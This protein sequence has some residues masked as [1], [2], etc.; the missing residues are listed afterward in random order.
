MLAELVPGREYDPREIRGALG[1]GG[2]EGAVVV[3]RGRVALFCRVDATSGGP[4]FPERSS[5]EWP[6]EVPKRAVDAKTRLLVFVRISDEAVRYLGE[7]RATRYSSR[8]GVACDVRFHITPPLERLWWLELIA[9]RLPP[10]GAPP[11][12]ALAN[13]TVESSTSERWA[14]LASFLERWFGKAFAELPATTETTIGPPLLRR[15]LRVHA[16][17][18]DVVMHNQLVRPEELI[19]EDGKIVFL[20]ENQGVCLWATEPDGEDPRVWY[21]NNTAGE[22]WIE[23][24]ET[25]SG[26]LIQAVLFEAIMHAQ[27]GASATALAADTVQAI[28]ARVAPLGNERWNWGGARF[29]ARDGALVMTMENDGACDV[30]LAAKTPF[31]LVQFEDLVSESWDRVAF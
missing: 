19:I 18:P 1:V 4:Y 5:L 2:G 30:W 10:A 26:F 31:A 7:G 24:S 15:M 25:L 27:F 3:G 22:P 28:L 16:L 12:E 29:F 17:I 21:R 11:E 20:V 6:G 14:A 23:E 13:S 9:G 8:K